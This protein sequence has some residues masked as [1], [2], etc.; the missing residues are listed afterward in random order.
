VWTGTQALQIGLVDELGSLGDAIK[1]AAQRVELTEYDVTS[2]PKKKDPFTQFL[3]GLSGGG[4]KAS[5]VKTFLG[6]DVYS[7]YLLSKGKVAPV[8]FVQALMIEAFEK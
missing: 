3:E 5:L 8:D 6:N 7:Q 2:H 1:I 4:V